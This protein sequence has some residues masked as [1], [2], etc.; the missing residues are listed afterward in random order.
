MQKVKLFKS[1][2]NEIN[3]LEAQINKWIV[4]E[5]VKIISVQGNIAPQPGKASMQGSFS[6]SDLFVIVLYEAP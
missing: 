5:K 3:D 6:Q 4:A 2:D 1:V